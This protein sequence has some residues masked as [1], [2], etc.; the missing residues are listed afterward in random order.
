ML[1]LSKLR[2]IDA[3]LREAKCSN[4]FFGGLTVVLVGDPA[5]LPP[6]VSPS[7]YS[8]QST[9]PFTNEGRAAYLA[10]KF[11]IKLTEV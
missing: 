10:F 6:V 4:S 2:K 7:L 8:Q 5:Q 11:V 9:A 3:R 1:S